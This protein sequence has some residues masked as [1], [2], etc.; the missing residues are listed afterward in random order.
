MK[1]KKVNVGK[2]I[3]PSSYELAVKHGKFQ[4]TLDEYLNKEMKTFDELKK[5][6][7][8]TKADLE[9]ILS[10][11]TDNSS[12]LSEL[13][14]ARNE[15][16][17]LGN[18]LDSIEE[19]IDILL[20]RINS[21]FANNDQN[22]EATNIDI[23]H[24]D[25]IMTLIDK[26]NPSSKIEIRNNGSIIQWRQKGYTLWEDLIYLSDIIPQL[27]IGSVETVDDGDADAHITG[28]PRNP[29]LNLKIPRG[30]KGLNGGDILDG[31][32]NENGEL[33]MTVT[34]ADED[35]LDEENDNN[36]D[37]NNPDDKNPLP[38]FRI[39][40]VTT[41]NWDEPAWASITGTPSNPIL[42]L[43]IPKGKPTKVKYAHI[44]ENGNI[45][46]ETE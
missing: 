25:L 14:N 30:K 38:V 35:N 8:G 17:T 39:G 26:D 27:K 9:K 24:G 19:D 21:R 36:G 2:I 6:A 18:R 1:Q 23:D 20:E 22:I 13:I 3:G 10:S 32:I 29:I 33:L 5:Y 42:N 11:L 45:I 46:F 37:C 15:Y 31:H 34:V 41:L 43:G 44:D 28:T 40:N 4:G 16:P 12:N 7:D